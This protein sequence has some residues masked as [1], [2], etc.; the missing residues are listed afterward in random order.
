MAN[1]Q[2]TSPD[3]LDK[4]FEAFKGKGEAPGK[5]T[6]QGQEPA[7]PY[8]DHQKIVDRIK[9][10][11]TNNSKN[12]WYFERNW[13]ASVL[14][15]LGN[16][17]I[18]WD[19]RSRNFRERK[20]RRYV[21]KPVN[22]R[23]ASTVDTVIAAVQSVK[24]MP[25]AWPATD[26]VDD[27]AAAEVAERVI[28]VIDD[29][30]DIERVRGEIAAWMVLNGDAFVFPYYDKTDKSLGERFVASERC[31]N[32]QA[33]GQPSQF[34]DGK[35]F[36]C[37]QVAGTNPA[38]DEQGKPIGVKYPAGRLRARVMSSLEIFYSM[39]AQNI[40]DL[41]SFTSYKNF[42]IK[43]VQFTYG[44]VAANLQADG[45]N[46]SKL[47]Q[48]YM[49]SLRFAT[50]D[51]TSSTMRMS[52]DQCTLF[53]HVELPS[54]DF[55]EGL[56][57]VMA[58]DETI[59][60]AGP[61]PFYDSEKDEQGEETKAFYLPLVQFPYRQVPGRIPS[62]TPCYDL[63]FKQD[64]LNQ[65]ES[66]IQMM[67]M[68]GAYNTWL[69]PTGSSI[70]SI[71]GEPSQHIKWTPSGTGGAKPELINGPAVAS[72]HMEYRAA[73]IADFED[74]GG[75]F[76][77]LKG[78]VPRGVSAG[79]AIQLLTERGYGRFG[80]VFNN[81]E[82]G[83]TRTYH[84]LL[85]LFRQY[86]TEARIARIKG[87]TGVWQIEKFV[88]ASLKGSV[89]LKIEGGAERPRSKLAEQALLETMQKMGVIN[90]Q[91]DDNQRFNIAEMFGMTHVLGSISDDRRQ[92]A[93][94]WDTFLKSAQPQVPGQP[95]AIL[96]MGTPGA[97]AVKPMVDNHLVHIVNH[98]KVA[99]T[100]VFDLLDPKV[101]EIW[102]Q[103]I[104]D[105]MIAMAPPPGAGAPP[106]KPGGPPGQGPTKPAPEAGSKGNE[107]GDPASKAQ[108]GKVSLGG[109]GT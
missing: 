20:M 17:W 66:L 60:E 64:Q 25:S 11:I 87:D 15:Y 44:D 108:H 56:V 71:T 90:P 45:A 102:E 77:A 101:R 46:I 103:H 50:S 31:A 81:W 12:R 30:I 33:V 48:Y 24:V 38:D 43:Q 69:L 58:A 78:N 85:S 83:W 54:D 100:D 2:I 8:D 95:P 9:E 75:T 74:L 109:G 89:D 82:R 72:G 98:Q 26:D 19:T 105:H 86:V 104:I 52:K 16:Q 42:P 57:A 49:T 5:L 18:T 88:G 35:C 73:I 28:P 79:Y 93:K 22:N 23:F 32:C 97:P 106:P 34:P 10:Q 80:P 21:P 53:T 1:E 63:M 68:K 3:V 41:H 47:S 67:V 62:K 99:K 107:M 40:D 59:L 6:E 29:E 4:I 37:G 27:I 84:I 70:V 51:S 39:D 92:A 91:M 65:V 55:P 13:F 7:S 36:S 94:E 76:D 61:S 96:V 14:Y